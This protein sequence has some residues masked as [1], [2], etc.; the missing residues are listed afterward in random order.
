MRC[1]G[2]LGIDIVVLYIISLKGASM[3]YKTINAQT[4]SCVR[5]VEYGTLRIYGSQEARPFSSQR[6][7]STNIV[8]CRVSILGITIQVI[9]I[10]GS[11][12]RN[13]K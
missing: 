8:E 3:R 6:V 13:N 12:P 2:T 4:V 5:T 1:I 10:W 7:Q 9:M 11:L